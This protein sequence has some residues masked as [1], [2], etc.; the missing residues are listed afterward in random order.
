[1]KFDE[2]LRMVATMQCHESIYS[3][4]GS[5]VEA[6][7]S[8]VSYEMFENKVFIWGLIIKGSFK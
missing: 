2:W 1:M 4:I 8:Y 7:A 3:K 6:V 5:Q